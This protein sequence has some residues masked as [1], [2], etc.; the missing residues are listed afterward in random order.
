MR[1]VFSAA[2]QPYGASCPDP[3]SC[4][5]RCCLCGG[6]TFKCLHQWPV[7]DPWN[8]ARIPIAVW[9]CQCELVFLHPVPAADQLPGG[10]DWW[11]GRRKRPRRNRTF[12]KIRSRLSH[13]LVGSPRYRLIKQTRRAIGPTPPGSGRLLD[14]GCG[15]GFLLQIASPYYDCVGLEPS[16]IAAEAAAARGFPVIEST[17]ERAAIEPASFDVLVMDSVIE[18]VADP[19]ATLRKANRVLKPARTIVLKTNKFNGPSYRRHGCAWNGFRHGYHTF[20]FT[21][22][23]LECTLQAAGFEVLGRPRRDRILDDILILW[24]RK[25]REVSDSADPARGDHVSEDSSIHTH[26]APMSCS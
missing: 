20:L 25:V 15:D 17:F 21:G 14:V 18:H 13:L 8:P 2:G 22:G 24:A 1:C 4:G 3:A 19:I 16:P 11:S 5:Y 7:G 12:K 10:G 23:T 6:R 9:Q 26:E